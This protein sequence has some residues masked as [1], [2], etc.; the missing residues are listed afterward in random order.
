MGIAKNQFNSILSTIFTA[1]NKIKLYSTVPDEETETGG[2]LITGDS[3]S[4]YEIQS[5]DFTIGNGV[6]SSAKNMLMYL[7]EEEAGHGTARGFG[8]FNP[9]GALLYF[10]TFTT[11]MYIDYNTVPT[12]KKYSS[13]KGEGVRITMTSTE[14]SATAE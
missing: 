8:V 5:G 1:G 6:V 13:S 3:Y 2:V 4:D 11:P 14:V 12:I 7:C 9:G 10:G